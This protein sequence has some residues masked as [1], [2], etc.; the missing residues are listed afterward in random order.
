MGTF[1]AAHT[2]A[3]ISTCTV[4][5]HVSQD[6]SCAWAMCPVRLK[7]T[8]TRIKL[9]RLISRRKASGLPHIRR[10][11]RYFLA[12]AESCRQDVIFLSANSESVAIANFFFLLWNRRFQRSVHFQPNIIPGI[13][14]RALGWVTPLLVF[15]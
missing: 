9:I 5:L 3:C 10:R 8:T 7:S 13:R 4:V 2:L 6:W 11:S 15:L 14:Q 1:S 12:Q